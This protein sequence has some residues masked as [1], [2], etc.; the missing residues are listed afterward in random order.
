MGFLEGFILG[1]GL[2]GEKSNSRGAGILT[3]LFFTAIGIKI[4]QTFNQKVLD[5]FSD[6][7]YILIMIYLL[8]NILIYRY[9]YK[10]YYRD[11]LIGVIYMVLIIFKYLLCAVLGCVFFYKIGNT[12]FSFIIE[13]INI[14]SSFVFYKVTQILDI[15]TRLFTFNILSR[16][17]IYSISYINRE[18]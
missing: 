6:K 3:F 5:Y 13:N 16:F 11:F 4:Y 2:T 18:E 7:L 14:E 15:I 12:P 9:S 8:L 10:K 1:K 17:I